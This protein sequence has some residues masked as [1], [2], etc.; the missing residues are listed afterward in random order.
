M[1]GEDPRRI[2]EQ[3]DSA[4]RYDAGVIRFAPNYSV[5]VLPP[6]LVCLYSED[7]KFFLQGELYCALASRIG[8]GDLQDA[9]VRELSHE[10]PAD[11]IEESFK[12]LFD[13]RFVVPVSAADDASAAYWASL[14]L[15]P[16]TAAANLQ[17]VSVGVRSL[18][19]AGAGELEAAL[20]AFGVRIVDGSADLIVVLVDDYLD[21]RLA[22]FNE[23]QLTQ[24]QDW[25]PVQASGLFPLVGPIFSPGK[26]ACWTCLADRMRANRQVKAFLDRRNARRVAASPLDDNLLGHSGV[27]LAA[28]EIG[29]AIASGFRTDLHQHLV[30][31]DLL[32]STL[33]RHYVPARPQCPSCGAKEL[34]DP[35]RPPAPIRLRA[36]GKLVMTS[37]GYRSVPPSETVARFRKHVSALTGVVSRLDRIESEQPLDFS[38]FAK[39]NFSPN[40]ESF[41]ALQ[42]GLVGDSH[43]KGSSCEQ[44]QASALMEA[45]ERYCGIFQGDEIRTTRSFADFAAG[46]A[47][48]PNDIQLFSE[49]QHARAADEGWC[50]DGVPRRFDPAAAIEWSPVWS[51]RDERFKHIPTSLLYFFHNAG[52]DDLI[53]DS[54]GCAA[55]NTLEE[56]I[57]QGFLEL[58]ERDAYAIW[59]YNRLRRPRIDLESLGDNYIRDLQAHFAAMGRR[60]WA[61]DVTSDLGVP[62]VVAVAHWMEDGRERIEV[63]AGAHF[64]LRIAALR[65]LTEINQFMA[66]ERM[67]GRPGDRI[68]PLPLQEHVY[69]MPDGTASLRRRQ[70]QKFA[71][72]DRREQV[73]A[74]VKLV[75]RH[76]HDFLV[77][78]QTRPDIE[79]PVVRVIVPGLRHFYRRFAPGRLYDAPLALGLRRR[80]LVEAEL[81]P[82]HPIM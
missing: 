51:L 34:R 62:V 66:I 77:L 48:P 58:V 22:A 60:L 73:L 75:E 61:L 39:H 45:I 21:G 53:A 42:A 25:L 35:A 43:G 72:L 12:R 81:N 59:W 26:S 23:Q 50:A 15:R 69:L 3:R 64:D 9:I 31:L 65:A 63:A 4:E 10:F 78:D 2:S 24:K 52:P 40:P 1:T 79:V 54:N 44:G 82:L 17:N 13:R 33:V 49:G 5:Y 27:S 68:D 46:E 56:A 16:E 76:G 38:Y 47:I 32:G 7:R 30:S 71:S 20:R 57:L 67:M 6:D 80:R 11:K 14:G 41:E 37:G 8:A 28:V 55:G 74:C 36:G 70:S 29:K 19:A 18:G